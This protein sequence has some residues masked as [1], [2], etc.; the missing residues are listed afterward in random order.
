M[1]AGKMRQKRVQAAVA[2]PTDG[3]GIVNVIMTGQDAAFSAEAAA[4]AEVA[5]GMFCRKGCGC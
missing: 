3:R 4:K 5:Y 2:R 1:C